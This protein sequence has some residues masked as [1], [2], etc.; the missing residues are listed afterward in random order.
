V[1]AAVD[2]KRV[3]FII[4]ALAAVGIG[5]LVILPFLMPADAVREAVKAEIRAVTGLD[6]VLRGGT[7]VSLF[8]TGAVSFDVL[9]TEANHAPVQ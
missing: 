3:G 9:E 2:I 5:A 1:T 4:L 8:P 7:S 6:P